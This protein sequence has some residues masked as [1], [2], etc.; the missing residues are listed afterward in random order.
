MFTLSSEE[1]WV[2]VVWQQTSREDVFSA[3]KKNIMLIT[4][5][6]GAERSELCALSLADTAAAIWVMLIKS[7]PVS[8]YK[9]VV[10]VPDHTAQQNQVLSTPDCRPESCYS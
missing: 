2:L 8:R 9:R 6:A 5:G 10:L 3:H 4:F 1:V 7:I